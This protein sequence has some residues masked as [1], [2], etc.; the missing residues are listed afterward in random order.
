MLRAIN[1]PGIIKNFCAFQNTNYLYLVLEY[2][3]DSHLEP[4]IKNNQLTEESRKFY[5]A[6]LVNIIEYLH[7]HGII[8]RDLK[9]F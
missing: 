6:E 4:L 3:P 7:S 9:V 5:V 2:C 1:H 8:H